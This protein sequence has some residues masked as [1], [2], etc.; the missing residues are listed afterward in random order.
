[1]NST[2]VLL[3][4]E[5]DDF[6]TIQILVD[7]GIQSVKVVSVAPAPP[8]KKTVAPT[9]AVPRELDEDR[10]SK[11]V[12]RVV[13]AAKRL[14]KKKS[15]DE[16]DTPAKSAAQD[17]EWVK[18]FLAGNEKAFEQIV[19]KYR[20]LILNASGR[21]VRA[22]GDAEEIASDTFIRAYKG[23]KNFRGDS[24]LKTWLYRIAVNLG[25]N[26][27]WYW[28]R[29]AIDRTMSMDASFGDGNDATLQDV[30]PAEAE[31]A[32]KELELKEL[33]DAVIKALDR[34]PQYQQEILRLRCLQF[35][36]YEEIAEITNINVGTVKSR[37][38]RARETL[39]QFIDPSHLPNLEE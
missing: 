36:S 3:T 24:T 6:E 12:D 26:R 28:Q 13:L 11:S 9:L 38:A 27:Y 8:I 22:S 5:D 19:L 1:V 16:I 39:R 20:G 37:I 23:L 21:Y 17:R 30:L 34:I 7:V 18:Q 25:R 32:G 33:Q 35:K 10:G 29:R 31:T 15:E 14:R 2:L 4:T